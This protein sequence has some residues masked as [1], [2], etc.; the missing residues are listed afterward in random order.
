MPNM[1]EVNALIINY[2]LIVFAILVG[3][4]HLGYKMS[5]IIGEVSPETPFHKYLIDLLCKQ[6]SRN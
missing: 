2:G 3:T 1:E 6:F 4:Y 5:K